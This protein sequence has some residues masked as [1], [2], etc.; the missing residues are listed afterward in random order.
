[1]KQQILVPRLGLKM[2]F[3]NQVKR[4][5]MKPNAIGRPTAC[6]PLLSLRF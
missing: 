2:A 1:M 5:H 4:V 3:M 6:G